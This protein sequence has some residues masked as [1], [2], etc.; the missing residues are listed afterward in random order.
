[1]LTDNGH[2]ICEWGG[3][4]TQVGVVKCGCGQV[5]VAS[6]ACLDEER[7]HV[8][9]EGGS[10]GGVNPPLRGIDLDDMD[11]GCTNEKGCLEYLKL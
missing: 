7:A 5:G 3:G 2:G 8:P 4:C 6:L 11:Q 9:D 1:M 10:G